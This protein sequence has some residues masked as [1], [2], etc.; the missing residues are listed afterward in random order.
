MKLANI[1]MY[2]RNTSGIVPGGHTQILPI[3][4]MPLWGLGKMKKGGHD[5]VIMKLMNK[6]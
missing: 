5:D 1:Y 6:S 4:R 3:L 2:V